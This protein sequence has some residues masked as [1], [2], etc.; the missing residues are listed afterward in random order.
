MY[1]P[2]VLERVRVRGEPHYF[3]VVRVDQEQ[4]YAQ[5][6]PLPSYRDRVRAFPFHMLERLDIPVDPPASTPPPSKSRAS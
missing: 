6:V 3:L 4:Q 1:I 5:V 2:G